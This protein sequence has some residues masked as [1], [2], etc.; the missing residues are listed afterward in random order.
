MENKLAEFLD[1]YDGSSSSYMKDL[2]YKNDYLNFREAF[3]YDGPPIYFT[4]IKRGGVS[5]FGDPFAEV[6]GVIPDLSKKIEVYA[7]Y[8]FEE[9]LWHYYLTDIK[10]CSCQIEDIAEQ[11]I[12]MLLESALTQTYYEQVPKSFIDPIVQ[13][14]KAGLEGDGIE[15]YSEK[16]IQETFAKHFLNLFQETG[17]K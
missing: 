9:Q 7:C 11:D 17:I 2:F 4:E 16:L 3:R 13:E 5:P 6:Y 8:D 15:F 14:L 1:Y 10:N 12:R